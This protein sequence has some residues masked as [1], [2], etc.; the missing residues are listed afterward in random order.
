LRKDLRE[1]ILLYDEVRNAKSSEDILLDFL[2]T[3]CEA[4]VDLANGIVRHSKGLKYLCHISS[5]RL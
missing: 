2:Q 1:F 5:A 3:T 4:A